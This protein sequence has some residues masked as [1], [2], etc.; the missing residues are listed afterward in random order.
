MRLNNFEVQAIRE[1]VSRYFE[2]QAM[3]YLFGSRV[4]DTKKGGDIDLYIETNLQGAELLRAKLQ[5]MSDIQ[6]A[7]GERKIDI[8]TA[9]PDM[10]T[11]VPLIVSRAR[12]EGI[13]L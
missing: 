5:T 13:R 1:A 6:R 9:A 2:P 7:I 3:V 12:Q 4:D 10:S 8:V 11:D